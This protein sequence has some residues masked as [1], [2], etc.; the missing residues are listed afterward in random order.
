MGDLGKEINSKF[1]NEKVKA[2]LNLN[3]QQVGLINW[4]RSS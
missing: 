2:L 3:I 4:V 1:P